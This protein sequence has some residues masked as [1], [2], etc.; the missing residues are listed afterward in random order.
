MTRQGKSRRRK[1]FIKGLLAVVRWVGANA[2][3]VLFGLA[4]FLTLPLLQAIIEATKPELLVRPA[5]PPPPPPPPV[6]EEEEPPEPEP[7]TE[8]PPPM[9]ASPEPL[10]LPSLSDLNLSGVGSGGAAVLMD[11][12]QQS[13]AQ[14]AG[15]A[16]EGSGADR[17]AKAVYQVSPKYPVA[18]RRQGVKGVVKV[19]AVVD[20]QGRVQSPK[21][22]SSPHPLFNQ[23]AIE[24]VK[25]WRFDPAL[26]GGSRIPSKVQ[27]PFRFE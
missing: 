4:V 20:A 9:E 1:A 15:D 18:L 10:P 6:V 26:R 21:V 25:Q 2:F 11:A 3:A 13:V 24:A 7:D 12:L 22:T 14:R 5:P 16:M 27:I 23:P 19:Q 17:A 8:P